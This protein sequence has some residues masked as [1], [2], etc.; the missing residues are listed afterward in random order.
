MEICK[1]ATAIVC[2][3]ACVCV[4]GSISRSSSAQGK[5]EP[6]PPKE[7]F[8]LKE[9]QY[10]LKVESILEGREDIA[11]YRVQIWT[12]VKKEFLLDVG[13]AGMEAIFRQ[14]EHS[15]LFRAA[16]V[17]ILSKRDSKNGTGSEVEF[18]C[19][20]DGD[21][22]T[23]SISDKVDASAKMRDLASIPPLT[24]IETAG[25]KAIGGFLI[26]KLEIECL[27]GK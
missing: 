7:Q 27:E 21:R 12:S 19:L 26:H 3:A 15:R 5:K 1:P 17:C 8:L 13:D 9:G 22:G 4:A 11:I 18:R 2:L 10:R 14:E 6:A 16:F 25:R 23:I 24:T 20:I